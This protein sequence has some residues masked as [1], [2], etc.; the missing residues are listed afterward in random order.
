ML[1]P[2]DGS[3][4][5]F[6]RGFKKGAIFTKSEKFFLTC[7]E[8]SVIMN[9]HFSDF[10]IKDKELTKTWAVLQPQCFCWSVQT[11]QPPEGFKSG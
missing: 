6:L 7:S 10:R 8:I 3:D 1:W 5:F 4:T 9:H 2:G 11:V